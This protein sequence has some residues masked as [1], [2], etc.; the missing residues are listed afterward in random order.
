M[1]LNQE[2]VLGILDAGFGAQVERTFLADLRRAREIRPEEWRRRPWY[3]RLRER[4]AELFDE[5]F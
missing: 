4:G 1:E 2:N 3:K 5:Q